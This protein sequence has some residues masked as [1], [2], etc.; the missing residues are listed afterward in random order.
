MKWTHVWPQ[1]TS[2]TFANFI[3]R[4]PLLWHSR[5]RKKDAQRMSTAG[6]L[7]LKWI[8]FPSHNCLPKFHNPSSCIEDT[9]RPHCWVSFEERVTHCGVQISPPFSGD[10]VLMTPHYDVSSRSANRIVEHLHS[11]ILPPLF[12]DWGPLHNWYP[13]T[14]AEG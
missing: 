12:R 14:W 9:T 1:I 5:E 4:F 10:R 13:F 7:T 8:S 6:L 11:L 3:V 2:S